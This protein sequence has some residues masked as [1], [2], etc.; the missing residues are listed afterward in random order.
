M[1][2]SE[3]LLALVRLKDDAPMFS[4][5]YQAELRQFSSQAHASS[6]RA[7]AMDSVFGGGGPLGEFIFDHAEAFIAAITTFGV[8]WL[9]AHFGRKLRLKFGDIVIEA[10]NPKEV[11]TMLEQVR[12]FQEK[13]TSINKEDNKS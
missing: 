4:A 6:Q 11:E 7:F 3:F 2:S 13:T 10:T 1:K 9:N 8:G 12:I 5:E